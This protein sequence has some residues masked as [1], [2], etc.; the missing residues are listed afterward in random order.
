[1]YTYPF[2]FISSYLCREGAIATPLRIF[3][4]VQLIVYKYFRLLAEPQ[5]A[6]PLQIVLSFII[7]FDIIMR[8]FFLFDLIF[9]FVALLNNYTSFLLQ[10]IVQPL[11]F[12]VI[13]F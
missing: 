9:V 7:P 2:L 10:Q 12:T 6:M 3:M 8:T 4:K 11:A 13:I 5:M 1:M